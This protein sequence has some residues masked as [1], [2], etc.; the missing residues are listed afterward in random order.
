VFQVEKRKLDN[1][2]NVKLVWVN[3]GKEEKAEKGQEG[4]S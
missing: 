2:N 4:E 3:K 1:N